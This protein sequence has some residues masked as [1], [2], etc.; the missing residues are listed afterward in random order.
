MIRRLGAQKVI[1][2][3]LV[4]KFAFAAKMYYLVKKV[5]CSWERRLS[6]WM[7]GRP[8]LAVWG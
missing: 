7:V 2:R 6:L 8:V 1:S 5:L 3:K 4:G